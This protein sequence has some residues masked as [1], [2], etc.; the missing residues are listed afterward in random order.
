[1]DDKELFREVDNIL[2]ES[3]NEPKENSNPVENKKSS[4]NIK[5]ILIIAVIVLFVV[6]INKVYT[7]E[8]EDTINYE[9]EQ[10]YE[11]YLEKYSEEFETFS[12]YK[13]NAEKEKFKLLR[14]NIQIKSYIGNEEKLICELFNANTEDIK[15]L[16]LYVIYY[17]AEK[18]PIAIKENNIDLIYA[19][20]YFY[21]DFDI[22]PDYNSFEFLI[23][24]DYESSIKVIPL[25]NIEITENESNNTTL[26][27][28][29]IVTV[30]NKS[31]KKIDTIE[32][33]II[34]YDENENI[35]Q[36]ETRYGFDIG[37]NGKE[38]IEFYNFDEEITNYK[39]IVNCA[40]SYK[41]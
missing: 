11:E 28:S 5:W 8:F 35:C 21:C 22:D 30:K 33:C 32:L 26:I 6:I 27:G 19:E 7:D 41:D 17:D 16:S 37:M 9:E 2:S 13:E 14:D 25:D 24:K 1:M 15:D 31:S 38:K 20:N 12:D 18:K 36:I 40:Y 34:Y 4:S 39:V 3:E 29:H 10:E 23:S